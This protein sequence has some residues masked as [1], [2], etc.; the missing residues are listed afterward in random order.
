MK[1]PSYDA[2]FPFL[3]FCDTSGGE[4]GVATT[5]VPNGLGPPNS[6]KNFPH[7]VDLLGQ[8]LFSKSCFRNFQG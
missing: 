8:P 4:M 3:F 2:Y 5:C 6:T 1:N 7:W